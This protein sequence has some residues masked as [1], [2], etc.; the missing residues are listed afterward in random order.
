MK[1]KLAFLKEAAVIPGAMTTDKTISIDKIKSLK[2]MEW[3][4][5]GL[6]INVKDEWAL[7]PTS[8]IKIAILDGAPETKKK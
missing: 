7:I 4:P 2:S 1:V 8:N 5:Q 3:T 6:L